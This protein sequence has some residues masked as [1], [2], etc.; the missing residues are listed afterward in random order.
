MPSIPPGQPEVAQLLDAR[1]LYERFVEERLVFVY[2]TL[3]RGQPN[4]HL[5]ASCRF[6]GK[7]A[8]AGLQLHDL[9]PFPMAIPGEGTIHGEVYGVPAAA[10]PA[11][12]RLEGVP[13]LYA[14]RRRR[15]DDGRRVWVYVGRPRQVRHSP[16]LPQGHWPA[17]ML[18]A[19]LALLHVTAML[20]AGPGPLP[21]TLA[22]DTL[23]TCGRWQN[24][25]GLAR[26][27]LGNALG[28]AAYL[29]K[30]RKLLES[31][32]EAPVALYAESDLHRVCAGWR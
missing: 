10:L 18:P 4:H 15:L 13:R 27:E 11:L 25:R 22:F 9:G 14:R 32:A 29:S 19:L 30:R 31:S 2:G 3:K 1:F 26:I 12:D 17:A 23:A 8:L 21:A 24:S 16:A 28:A 5:L 7:A 20:P 6:L